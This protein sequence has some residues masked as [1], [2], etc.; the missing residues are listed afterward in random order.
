MLKPVPVAPASCLLHEHLRGF[1]VHGVGERFVFLPPDLFVE[2]LLKVLSQVLGYGLF[3]VLLHFVIDG[4][5]DAQ[6]VPVQIVFGAVGLLVLVE[7]SI[8][9]IFSP[10]QG[11]LAVILIPLIVASFRLRG[12]HVSSKHIP[13][14]RCSSG[15]VVLHL[16]CKSDRYLYYGIAFFFGDISVPCHLAYYEIAAVESHVGVEDRIVAGRLVDHSH[17]HRRLFY[18]EIGRLF[19][20]ERLRRCFDSVCPA[21]EENGVEVHVDYFF[22][23]VVPFQL[24]R[25]YP[26]FEFGSDH[27]DFGPAGNLAVHLFARV[28]G[29]CELLGDGTAASLA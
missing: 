17:E 4:G 10:A 27:H 25:G 6:T 15:V 9:R 18:R 3:G 12:G 24:D 21:S 1:G 28:Q 16:I 7:P 8:D 2:T 20:E 14:V 19:G 22:F 26:F 11:I 13:E 29:L 23:G 5:I